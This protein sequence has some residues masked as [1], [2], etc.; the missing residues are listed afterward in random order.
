[1]KERLQKYIAKC[2]VASRRKAEELILNGMIKVNGKTINSII[3]VDDEKD[4]VEYDNKVI[5]PENKMIYVMLNKPH[6]V[7]TTSHDQFGRKSVLDIVKTKERIYPVGRLDYD[8]SGL[9]LLTNDGD[10]TYSLTHPSHKVNKTYIAEIEGCPADD[11]I[12]AFKEGLKI[13]NYVTSP[14][15]FK[16]LS[17]NKTAAAAEITIHEGHNRQVRK[18][19]DKIGHK[20]IRLKRISIGNLNIG[21]LEEGKYRMLTADEIDY[22]KSI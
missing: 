16:V 2:G 17:K 4:V 7:V 20:V 8:T 12:R 6:G 9:L 13:E 22:I 18:M 21:N 5:K 1:M 3:T 19:C 15:D 11:E 14:A 10:V